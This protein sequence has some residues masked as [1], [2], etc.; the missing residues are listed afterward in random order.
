M[1]SIAA[2]I[3]S[4][5]DDVAAAQQIEDVSAPLADRLGHAVQVRGVLDAERRRGS[6][7]VLAVPRAPRDARLRVLLLRVLEVAGEP[8]VRVVGDGGQARRRSRP[9]PRPSAGARDRTRRGGSPG[10]RSR[11][12]RIARRASGSACSRAAFFASKRSSEVARRARRG[13]R[14]GRQMRARRPRPRTTTMFTRSP[15]PNVPQAVER[16]ARRT[17]AALGDVRAAAPG[18]A[19][20]ARLRGASRAVGLDVRVG[21][22]LHRRGAARRRATSSARRR[23]RSRTTSTRSGG[24]RPIRNVM[25]ML[26]RRKTKTRRRRSR[27]RA[28]ARA[29]SRRRTASPCGG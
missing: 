21:P 2:R 5:F 17:A 16:S 6:G 14:D 3:A 11:T 12:T 24:T 8:D 1:S 29:R 10:S 13:P 4:P 22:R 23:S 19:A 7:S 15:S 20:R 9:A 28:C 25:P 26:S 27:A 18:A